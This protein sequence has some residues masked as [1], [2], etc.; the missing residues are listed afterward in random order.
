MNWIDIKEETTAMWT[1]IFK[2]SKNYILI[3]N[4]KRRVKER[5]KKKK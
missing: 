5:W 1:I 4:N 3:K 2:K